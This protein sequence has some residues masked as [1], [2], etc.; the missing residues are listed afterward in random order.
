MSSSLDGMAEF[1]AV[2]ESGSFS[3]AAAGLAISKSAISK[4]VAALEARLG[5]RLLHRTT[6]RVGLT[7]AGA[8]FYEAAAA[9]L[10]QA[11]DATVQASR[12]QEEPRG[13]LRVNAPMSFGQSQIAPALPSFMESYPAIRIDLRLDDRI[14]DLFDGGFDLAVRIAA[15]PDSAL[16]ARRLAPNNRLV[17]ASPDYFRRRGRPTRPEDLRDHRCLTY[18]YLRS[19]D[20]WRFVGRGGRHA[21][22]VTGVLCANNGDALLEAARAGLGVTFLPTFIIGD[23]LRSGRLETCLDDFEVEPTAVYAVYPERR[24]LPPKVRVLVDFLADRFG[25]VPVWDRGLPTLAARRP[26]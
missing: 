20:E 24:H 3:A 16:V 25:D 8:D 9:I 4:R 6:R 18:A 22:R 21:V 23:D 14:V 5:V 13:H 15:M 7:E 1:A 26:G 11:D 19:H 10:A 12:H 2:V 17:C